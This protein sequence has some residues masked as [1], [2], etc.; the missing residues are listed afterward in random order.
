MIV[1]ASAGR[2]SSPPACLYLLH[3]QLAD[4]VPPIWRRLAVPGPRTLHALHGILQAAMPWQDYHLYQFEIS[5]TRYED[6]NPDDRDPSIPDPR[7]FTLDHLGLVQG[8]QFQYTYD[9]GD[10]W[11]HDLTVE[12]V[13]PLPRDFM[14]PVCLSGARACPPE[15]CGGVGG[16]EELVAALRRP[17]SAAA[18]EFRQWLGRV[19]DPEELD[20]AAINVRLDHRAPRRS[21]PG[22]HRPR[23]GAV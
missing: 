19:H 23:R 1:R 4:I 5:G 14:L 20:L 22:P 9:F 10:D 6:P 18:R 16:Y 11:L 13:V 21:R 2:R 3:V 12:G 7:A 17:Q 8:S 15:D